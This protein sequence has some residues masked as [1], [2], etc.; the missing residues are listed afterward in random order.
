MRAAYGAQ[1]GRA[2]AVSLRMPY[3]VILD[4]LARA[5]VRQKS[6]DAAHRALQV[7][8]TLKK[9]TCGKQAGPLFEQICSMRGPR[10]TAAH[11]MHR[12]C[13]RAGRIPTDKS[14][15]INILTFSAPGV[16]RPASREERIARVK[17]FLHRYCGRCGQVGC[18]APDRAPCGHYLN[19][20]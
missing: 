13:K 16:D 7:G 15:R 9:S 1:G 12:W 3:G 11:R 6:V 19:A 2:C 20:F 17:Q 4:H 10:V 14:I 18:R 8:E 5:Q